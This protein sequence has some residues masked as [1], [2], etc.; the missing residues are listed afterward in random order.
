[1][2][3]FSSASRRIG[4]T[5]GGWHPPS[6]KCGLVNL[7]LKRIETGRYRTED[8]I[9]EVWKELDCNVEYGCPTRWFVNHKSYDE[10]LYTSG[11]RKKQD[12]VEWLSINATEYI[13]E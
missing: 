5:S 4:G 3:Q 9:F 1:V 6:G 11:F 10:T 2:Q 7:K 8:G 12:A 13:E